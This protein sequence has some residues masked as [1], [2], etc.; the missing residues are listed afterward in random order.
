MRRIAAFKNKFLSADVLPIVNNIS[1]LFFDRIL[2]MGISLL[3]GVWVAR[4]LGPADFGTWNYGIAIVSIFSVLNTLG[5]ENIVIKKVVS[6]PE[7]TNTI[8]GSAFSLRLAG[9][10]IGMAGATL[11][12]LLLDGKS[13]Q[14]VFIV[15]IGSWAFMF[16]SFDIIATYYQSHLHAK[17]TVVAKTIGFVIANLAKIICVFINANLWAFVWISFFEIVIGAIGL[18]SFYRIAGIRKWLSSKKE[19]VELLKEGWPLFISSLLIIIYMRIDQ[20]MLGSML[21]ERSVG[22]YSV[23]VRIA[24]IWY[25]IPTVIIS[26]VYPGLVAFRK[27]NIE[28]YRKRLLAIFK[29]F[30]LFSLFVSIIFAFSSDFI[31]QLLY[32]PDYAQSSPILQVTIW[33]GIFVFLGVAASTYMV[34]EGITRISLLKTLIGAAT[35]VLLNLFLIPLYGA[36]GAAIATLVAYF[37]AAYLSNVFFSKTRSLFRDMNRAIFDSLTILRIKS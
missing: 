26:S 21:G 11:A 4:H 36:M 13:S 15:L 6:Q 27:N 20:V 9:S 29:Y 32:G 18:V 37:M 3:V 7:Q 33:S 22:I 24:E 35:N 19:M 2:R 31:V 12:A 25:F 34:I 14:L 5:L 23:A 17:K 16:Q 1:W 30:F 10:V 28:M 8:L